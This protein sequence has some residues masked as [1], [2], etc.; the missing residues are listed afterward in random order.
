[1]F[2]ILVVIRAADSPIV[3]LFFCFFVA[4]YFILGSPTPIQSPGRIMT[5]SRWLETYGAK[6][7]KHTNSL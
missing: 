4:L 3:L 7:T 5:I 1:M 6:L 2:Q